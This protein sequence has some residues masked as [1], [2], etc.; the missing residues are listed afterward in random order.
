MNTPDIDSS[1]AATVAAAGPASACAPLLATGEHLNRFFHI[2]A[3]EQEAAEN[4]ADH[5]VIIARLTPVLHP[6]EQR[7]I[8]LEIDFVI[9]G[10]VL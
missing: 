6:L 3:T 4:A 9:L 5:L 10:E 1:G 7:F 2:I 8:F